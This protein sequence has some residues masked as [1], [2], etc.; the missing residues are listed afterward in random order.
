MIW[1]CR[2]RS[3]S[4]VLLALLRALREAASQPS[5]R[6]GC[7]C[8]SRMG[9][10]IFNSS[11]PLALRTCQREKRTHGGSLERRLAWASDVARSFAGLDLGKIFMKFRSVNATCQIERNFLFY[12]TCSTVFTYHDRIFVFSAMY[13]D[14]HSRRRVA[15]SAI[16][17]LSA[18]R[19]PLPLATRRSTIWS[20]REGEFELVSRVG[21][22]ERGH[23]AA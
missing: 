13:D 16:S 18:C 22:V 9:V 11:P 23:C 6:S 20:C 3:V 2:E 8:H 21:A 15:L 12:L 5:C 14:V 1:W 10:Y 19:P 4:C 17:R 7:N